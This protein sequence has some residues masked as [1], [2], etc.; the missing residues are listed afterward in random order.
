MVCCPGLIICIT[1]A[2]LHM[3]FDV[4]VRAGLPPIITVGLPGAQGAATTGEQ[5]WGVSTPNAAEVA[6]ATA[7][8]AKELHIPKVGKL[9]G[10]L[11]IIVAKGKLLPRTFV[12]EVT[13]N[14]QGAAPKLH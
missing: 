3:T 11:S 7:G 8:F 4:L 2:Q 14:V 6:A 5:G 12:T 9:A 13:I 1:P 10:V